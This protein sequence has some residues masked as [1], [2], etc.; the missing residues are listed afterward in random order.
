MKADEL[1]ERIRKGKAPLIL[2][3]RTT[4]EF[5]SGHIVGAVHAPLA[6]ILQVVS[7]RC[8]SRDDL[9]VL[10][11][12]HGP[13]AQVSKM[14]LKLKGYRNVELLAGHMLGWRRAGRPVKTSG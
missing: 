10:T 2:D 4:G 14:L 12:E 8:T 13:R 3:V 11:C 6:T 1:M 7:E 5:N 9:L